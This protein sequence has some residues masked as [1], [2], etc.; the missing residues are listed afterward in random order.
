MPDPRSPSNATRWLVALLVLVVLA[1]GGAAA[2]LLLRPSNTPTAASGVVVYEP[3][4]KP[5]SNPFTAPATVARATTSPTPSAL[6]AQTPNSSPS[7]SSSPATGNSA[8]PGLSSPTPLPPGTFGG[9]GS[10]LVCDREK[11]LHYLHDDPARLRVW[12]SVRGIDPGNVDAYVRALQ[13]ATLAADM[14]VTNHSFVNGNAQAYQS[15]LP[16]G[17]AVLLDSSGQV[18]TRCLCGNPLTAAIP[19]GQGRCQGCPTNGYTPPPVPAAGVPAPAAIEPNPPP[20]LTP[21]PSTPVATPSATASATPTPSPTPS[22]PPTVNLSPS[23]TA[24]ASSTTAGY[25]A[26]NVVDGDTTT[27]WFST[28]PDSNTG[29]SSLTLVLAAPSTVSRIE[30]VGNENQARPDFRTG[31]GYG[32]WTIDL[33]D[34]SGAVLYTVNSVAPADRSQSADFASISGVVR[35]RFTGYDSQSPNCG[36]FAE[37]RVLGH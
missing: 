37:L 6:A 11:L 33:M 26:S 25:P 34:G 19:I 1:G 23:A 24:T 18:V 21:S 12:A 13:P 7:S 17:T 10:N 20:V 2:F 32:R 30:F 14:R 15:I 36:G 28:G 31:F 5:G 9:S 22:P 29:T 16:A 4:D 35:V 3:P 27:S 8:S